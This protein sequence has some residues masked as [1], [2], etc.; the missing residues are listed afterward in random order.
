MMEGV[1]GQ[2]NLSLAFEERFG[3]QVVAGGICGIDGYTVVSVSSRW[4]EAGGCAY[5]LVMSLVP[6]PPPLSPS[7]KMGSSGR[8]S[9][10]IQKA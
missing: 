3:F 10:L 7:P 9:S 1:E 6:P 8:L 5:I 2:D 4:P